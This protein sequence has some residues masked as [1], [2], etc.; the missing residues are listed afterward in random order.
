MS[1]LVSRLL[2]TVLM[3]PLA[4]MVYLVALVYYVRSTR[5][6][7]GY[8]GFAMR[9]QEMAHVCAGL[10]AWMFVAL[11]WMLLWRETVAWTGRRVAQTAWLVLGAIVAGLIIG[12]LTWP[13]DRYIGS[14]VGSAC[15]PLLWVVGTI[16]AWRETPAESAQRLGALA[17]ARGGGG[18]VVCPGCGYNLTGLRE[19]RCPECG[20]AYTLDELFA[21]QPSRA[22]AEIETTS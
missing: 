15:A 1:R 17:S 13:L 9:A 2:L 7:Y 21:A 11:Y 8:S 18:G 14:F 22:A 20:T 19:A 16:F 3:L 6:Y 4:S 5:Y 12:A 10:I